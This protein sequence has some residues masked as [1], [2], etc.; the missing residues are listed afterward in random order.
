[1]TQDDGDEGERLG[2]DE[3]GAPPIERGAAIE[4][5]AD[6][7]AAAAG[8]SLDMDG[9]E[10]G[11]GF[12]PDDVPDEPD[13]NRDV[14][15]MEIRSNVFDDVDLDDAELASVANTGAADPVVDE[16]HDLPLLDEGPPSIP[17]RPSGETSGETRPSGV[18]LSLDASEDVEL[19][20][21]E[22]SDEADG[23]PGLSGLERLEHQRSR[24][25]GRRLV[26]AATAILMLGAGGLAMGYFGVVQI[27]GITPPDRIRVD[28]LAPVTLPGPQ[29]ETPVMSHVVLVDSWR[30]VETPLAWASALREN[31]TRFMTIKVM[32]STFMI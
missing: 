23:D 7:L 2:L 21:V 26:A 30:E 24:S 20:G 13:M 27:P 31:Q 14:Q 11:A 22:P 4:G 18:A 25:G 8:T 19:S 12:D 1:M 17:T 6:A 29:P 9:F 28:V 16:S 10:T 5:D 15:A 3:P 32:E